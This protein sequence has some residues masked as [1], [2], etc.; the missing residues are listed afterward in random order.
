MDRDVLSTW[1]RFQGKLGLVK[2]SN[3]EQM[4]KMKGMPRSVEGAA[5]FGMFRR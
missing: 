3:S 5:W 2:Q 4:S 1:A